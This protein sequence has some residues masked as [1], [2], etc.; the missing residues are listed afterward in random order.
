MYSRTKHIDINYH[1]LREKVTNK[2]VKVEYVSTSEKV[3]DIF[4]KPLPKY[5]FEYLRQRMVLSLPPSA[6]K[7]S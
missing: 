5:T 7:G 4:T 2:E 1:F 3:D 6:L